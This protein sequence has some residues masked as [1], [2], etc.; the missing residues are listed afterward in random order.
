MTDLG[1]LGGVSSHGMGI[2]NNRQV[3]GESA[4]S[5]NAASLAFLNNNGAMND[6]GTLPGSYNS[7]AYGIN[8]NGQVV[9]QANGGVNG[10]GGPTRLPLQ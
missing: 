1:T 7:I 9:V 10:N 2:N 4:T 3:A 8:D 5:G 6:R